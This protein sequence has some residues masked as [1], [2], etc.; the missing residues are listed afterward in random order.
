M[1]ERIRHSTIAGNWYPG[2]EETL[3]RTVDGLLD[4]AQASAYEGRDLLAL[5]VPHAGYNYSGAVAAQAYRLLKGR[6]FPRVI[7]LGPSHYRYIGPWATTDFTHYQ[8]PLGLVPVDDK[9]AQELAERLSML[10]LRENQEHALEIQ[11]PFLQSLLQEFS[12]VPILIGDHSLGAA[13]KLAEALA[14]TTAD[15]NNLLIA[16]SDLSHYHNART[17]EGM[18]RRLL[19]RLHSL[20]AEG[21][22]ADFESGECEACGAGAILA[23]MLYARQRGA[24]RAEVLKYAHS[25]EIIGDYLGV[26]GYAAAAVF[27]PKGI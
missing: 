1:E 7:L 14:E 26:V 17:A 25:G 27:L 18:D 15:E 8:T 6:S 24:D 4:L 22:A 21:L 13:Q 5:F 16:S 2:T 23:A 9:Y 11:L 10:S 12:V 19:S 20:Y 3:R